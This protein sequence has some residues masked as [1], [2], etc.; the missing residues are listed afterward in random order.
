[1]NRYLIVFAL[2]ILAVLAIL[3]FT[4]PQFLDK[5]WMWLVGFAGY[6]A[7]FVR[8]ASD[9]VKSFFEKPER[10]KDTIIPP[11]KQEPL[12]SAAPSGN[13]E[14]RIREIEEKLKNEQP[15]GT[16]LSSTYLSVLRYLDDGQTTLGLLFLDNRF[17]AYTLE[18]THRDTKVAG[19]T[20]VPS[21]TYPLELNKNLTDLTK[22]YR[23]RFPW[24]DYHVELMNIPNFS[25]VYIHI[26]NTHKDTEGCILIADGVN[27]ADPQKMVSHSRLAFER[28]YKTI[29]P[30]LSE[31]KPLSIQILDEDW[32]EKSHIILDEAYA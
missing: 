26:G 2:I 29:H 5:I 7:L 23:N 21:G 18:D 24:F 8:K 15:E 16:P 14:E 12:P 1:M 4:Q 17:F 6:V 27:A 32:F 31:G 30:L 22:T 20:R 9:T 25:R 13:L 28:F 19:S 3:F 11:E 10:S